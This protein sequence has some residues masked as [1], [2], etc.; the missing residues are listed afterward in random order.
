MWPKNERFFFFFAK[1]NKNRFSTLSNSISIIALPSCRKEIEYWAIRRG[2]TKWKYRTAS[3]SSS[4]AYCLDS[5]DAFTNSNWIVKIESEWIATKFEK[6]NETNERDLTRSHSK[7]SI[8]FSR[9][10]IPLDDVAVVVEFLLS[11]LVQPPNK[12]DNNKYIYCIFSH[13]LTLFMC[14]VFAPNQIK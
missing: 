10:N 9:W 5:R 1:T 4:S 12:N 11:S 14:L 6:K 13:Q 7:H 3:S 2:Y 8:S